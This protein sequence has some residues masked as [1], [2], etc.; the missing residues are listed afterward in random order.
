MQNVELF[1]V[2]L[3]I[4]YAIGILLWSIRILITWSKYVLLVCVSIRFVLACLSKQRTPENWREFVS[5]VCASGMLGVGLGAV[6]LMNA[7]D[8]N[9][10]LGMPFWST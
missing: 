8:V 5:V 10:K 3:V 7:Y 9:H 4:V 6:K 2:S 1:L